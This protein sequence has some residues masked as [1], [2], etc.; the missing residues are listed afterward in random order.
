MR[1][2][3]AAV[4]LNLDSRVLGNTKSAFSDGLSFG[5]TSDLW[6]TKARGL[7]IVLPLR[8]STEACIGMKGM[9]KRNVG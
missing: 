3:L 1:L 8:I 7:M 6:N 9:K 5:L 2:M 4:K